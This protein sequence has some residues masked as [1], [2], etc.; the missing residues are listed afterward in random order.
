MK[1]VSLSDLRRL[2]AEAQ[3]APRRRLNRN[4]HDRLDDPI[5]RL[6]NALEPGTYIRPHRHPDEVWESF[7][8]LSGA[9]AIVLFDTDGT[10]SKRVELSGSG[11]VIAEIPAGAWHAV[12]ALAADTVVVEVKPGPYLPGTFAAWAPAEADPAAA[13]CLSWLE[14]AAPGDRYHG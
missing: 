7:I 9:C 8:L 1:S 2:S 11:T 6:C 3:A 4:L 12:V 14:R 5:Q 10:V 13:R